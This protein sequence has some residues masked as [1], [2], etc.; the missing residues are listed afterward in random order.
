[1]ALM[2][3]VK[4]LLERSIIA[5][6]GDDAEPFLKGLAT[7]GPPASGGCFSALLTPQGKILFDFF[8]TQSANGFWLDVH[9]AAAEALIKRLTLYRLRAK[10]GIELDDNHVVCVRS[11]Y[12]GANMNDKRV[13]AEKAAAGSAENYTTYHDDRIAYGVPEWGVDFRSE[14][15]FPMDVNYDA[16][17]GVDYQKGCFVGQEVASRMKRKGGARKRTLIAKFDGGPPPKG[18]PVIAGESTLGH[19]LSGVEGAALALIRLDRLQE[20][21]KNSSPV[22]CNGAAVRLRTPNY[23]QRD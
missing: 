12:F 21:E 10:V 19:I 14:E 7:N 17:G 20:A 6:N 23:L 3:D 13:I 1:M 18:S 2:A 5:V 9:E 15:V 4:R 8:I 11:D 16:L 22:E